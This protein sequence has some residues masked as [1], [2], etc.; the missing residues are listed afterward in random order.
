M[1]ILGFYGFIR[2]FVIYAETT[3]YETFMKVFIEKFKT[4]VYCE[5][6]RIYVI[7]SNK[8]LCPVKILQNY[9][10]FALINDKLGEYIFKAISKVNITEKPRNANK[11]LLYTRTR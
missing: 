1:F 8:N 3:F 5:G 4:D 10:N 2:K 9:L 6:D 11:A 7:K